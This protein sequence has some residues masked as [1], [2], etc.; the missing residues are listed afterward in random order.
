M[1]PQVMPGRVL[2]VP[3]LASFLWYSAYMEARFYGLDEE[4]AV[5]LAS[6]RCILKNKDYARSQ[7]SDDM[8]ISVPLEGSSSAKHLPPEILSIS[9]HGNWRHNHIAALDTVFSRTPAFLFL[10]DDILRVICREYPLLSMLTGEIHE[11]VKSFLQLDM[12][13][14]ILMNLNSSEYDRI[15]KVGAEMYAGVAPCCSMVAVT[16]SLGRDA[17]FPLLFS[18][19]EKNSFCL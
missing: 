18:L 6:S 1:G 19:S 2:P 8:R 11:V 5:N 13:I 3:Y 17:I 16:S 15:I 4:D 7:I 9:D 12:L 10:R 14:E